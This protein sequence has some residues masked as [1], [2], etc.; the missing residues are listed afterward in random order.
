M[1]EV[2]VEEMTGKTNKDN[3]DSTFFNWGGISF[4][5]LGAR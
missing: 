2:S 3:K 1:S 4:Q 5:I